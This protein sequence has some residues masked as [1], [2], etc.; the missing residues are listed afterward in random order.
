VRHLLR[1]LLTLL[2]V[3]S[4]FTPVRAA[5]EE[6]IQKAVNRAVEALRRSQRPDGRWS[7][8]GSL[9]IMSGPAD[10]K[11]VGAT[12]LAGLALVECGIGPDDPAVARAAEAVR[13][14]SIELTY[15]YAASLAILFLDRLG[16]PLDVPLIESL[17]L[18]LL[19]GQQSDGGWSYDCPAIAPSEVRRLKGT[20]GPRQPVKADRQSPPTRRRYEDLSDEVKQQLRLAE[21]QVLI[22]GNGRSDNSNTQFASLALWVGRRQGLPVERA[23]SRIDAR[24]RA[25]Q[26]G[27]GGWDYSST[28]RGASPAM[29][30]AGLLGLGVAHGVAAEI[31]AEKSTPEGR[32]RKAPHAR[33]PSRD[34]AVRAGLLY[35]GAILKMAFTGTRTLP[36]GPVGVA[37]GG[38]PEGVPAVPNPLWALSGAHGSVNYCL[39]SVER[40]AVAYGLDT[41]GKLDWYGQGA[42]VLL[43]TQAVGGGWHHGFTGDVCETSFGLLFLRRANLASDLTALLRGRVKDPGSVSLRAGGVGAEALKDRKPGGDEPEKTARAAKPAEPA[44]RSPALEEP[45]PRVA[46]KQAPATEPAETA[47]PAT[48][49]ESSTEELVRSSPGRQ[50]FLI[51]K[52]QEAKGGANTEILARAIPR[53]HGAIKQKARD[54][55]AERLA[56]MT[57]STLSDKLKDDNPEVRRAAVL[58]SAMKDDR[59]LGPALIELLADRDP[60]VA[61]AARAALRELSGQDF[62][63]EPNADRAALARSITRWRDWWAKGGRRKRDRTG[64]GAERPDAAPERSPPAAEGTDQKLLQGAW[65]VSR[66]EVAGKE[67]SRARL[68]ELRLRLVVAGDRITMQ[69]PGR[70]K[71]LTFTLD[72]TKDPREIDLDDGELLI[73]RGIYQLDGDM[74]KIC[75]A[76]PGAPRPAE[77]ATEAISQD[78]LYILKRQKPAH[79]GR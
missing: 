21:R 1:P 70:T 31:R 36:E 18:R 61:R 68:A 19:A 20:L 6:E 10:P 55:L 8:G 5:E 67:V 78:T 28:G 66:M 7:Y 41:I 44:K 30:C 22:G 56:R 53:L 63:P 49:V 76:A 39:W 4:V 64:P 48:E 52:L 46:P 45:K 71:N 12:A 34:P 69:W 32:P 35:L 26:A 58:A 74:L 9:S 42:D 24:F 72:A 51:L 79:A 33:E 37:R 50:A 14:A 60:A 29:T 13:T 65:A 47:A 3:L 27:D 43:K 75:E 16:D 57:T 40:V 38:G 59:Q 15:T 23:L 17:T 54:A 11:D 62:G 77:F 25:S 2:L 73:T